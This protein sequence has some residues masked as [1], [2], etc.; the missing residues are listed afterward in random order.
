MTDWPRVI[1]D[2]MGD[3]MHVSHSGNCVVIDSI[4]DYTGVSVMLT[5][6]QCAALIAAITDAA[7]VVTGDRT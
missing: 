3:E 5:V 7:K 4:D 2:V 1:T 6:D